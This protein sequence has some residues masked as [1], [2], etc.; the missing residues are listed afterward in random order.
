MLCTEKN[1]KWSCLVVP[2]IDLSLLVLFVNIYAML[3]IHL[4][5]FSDAVSARLL[6][7]CDDFGMDTHW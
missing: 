7:C 1:I 4:L 5:F 2:T 3:L 6:V